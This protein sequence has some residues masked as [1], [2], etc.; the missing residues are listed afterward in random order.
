MAM[1]KIPVDDQD[2]LNLS[3]EEIAEQTSAPTGT[4]KWRLHAALKRLRGLLKRL[5]PTTITAVR[6]SRLPPEDKRAAKD[7]GR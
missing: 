6:D 7:K 2:Y 4:V 5:G 1:R 3:L